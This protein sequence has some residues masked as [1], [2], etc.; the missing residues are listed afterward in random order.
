MTISEEEEE[1]VW[2]RDPYA[3]YPF[4][5]DTFVKFRNAQYITTDGH[6]RGFGYLFSRAGAFSLELKGHADP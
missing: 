3:G 5:E 6:Q 4:G 1:F 2:R